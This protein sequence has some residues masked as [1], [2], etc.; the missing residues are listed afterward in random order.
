MSEDKPKIDI[1]KKVPEKKTEVPVEDL[2]GVAGG[3]A[4]SGGEG[5]GTRAT[6]PAAKPT[7]HIPVT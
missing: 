3:M 7:D 1:E 2:S 6:G 4:G 5:G